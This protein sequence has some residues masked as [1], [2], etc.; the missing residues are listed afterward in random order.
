MWK[1]IRTDLNYKGI[2]HRG[3]GGSNLRDVA[4]Y[5]KRIVYPHNPKAIFIYVGNDITATERDKSPDQVLELY[6]YIVKTIREKYPTTPITWLAISP[7]EKRWSVW[8]KIQQANGLVKIYTD[9]QP[10]LFFIDA[11]QQFLGTDGKPN[12]TLYRDDKLHYNDEGYKLWGK[13]IKESVNKIA[14]GK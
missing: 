2:I 10:N 1:N 13:S 14:A 5:I 3:F 4:Y 11:G 9:S 12:A 8:E 7:S 6:K